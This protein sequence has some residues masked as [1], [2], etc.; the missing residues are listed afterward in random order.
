MATACGQLQRKSVVNE[1]QVRVM[2]RRLQ[3]GMYNYL[4]NLATYG[5]GCASPSSEC[6]CLL[7]ST[8]DRLS[9]ALRSGYE[10]IVEE[11]VMDLSDRSL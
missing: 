11:D 9:L 3:N 2:T 1:Q 10:Y 5:L 6:I 7:W 4:G 8:L